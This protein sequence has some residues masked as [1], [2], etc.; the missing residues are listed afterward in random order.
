MTAEVHIIL[1]R[2]QKVL[3]IPSDAL[4]DVSGK[5]AV[6][7]VLD[8]NGKLEARNI[9]TGLNNKVMVEVVSGLEEGETVVTGVSN[10]TMPSASGS[11]HRM[12]PF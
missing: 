7:N 9:E 10:G 4:N 3:L 8:K 12:G 5:K 2:A 11:R 1:G 6:V